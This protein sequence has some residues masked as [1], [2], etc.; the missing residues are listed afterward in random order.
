MASLSLFRRILGARFDELPEVL[1]RFHGSTTGGQARGTFLVERGKGWLRNAVASLLGM[2]K[3]GKDVP[4]R[5]EV[6][7]EGERER[8]FRHFPGQS[9]SS[10]QWAERGLLLESFGLGCFAFELVIDGPRL[11]HEFRRAWFAGIPIPR[12]LAPFVDGWLDAGDKGWLVVVHVVF[13]FLGEI[14]HYEGWVEPD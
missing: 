11:R 13:P 10:L 4:V 1:Q 2:P 12:A 3:A 6:V 7:V 8:W 5:L 14:V 9:L